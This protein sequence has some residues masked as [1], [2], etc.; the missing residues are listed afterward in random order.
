MLGIGRYEL[1]IE[2]ILTTR[3]VSEGLSVERAGKDPSMTFFKVAHF[4]KGWKPST[5][6]AGG[7]SHRTVKTQRLRPEGPSH[8]PLCRPSGPQLAQPQN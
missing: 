8:A 4:C 2:R 5:S 6:S 3:S 1:L 7:V